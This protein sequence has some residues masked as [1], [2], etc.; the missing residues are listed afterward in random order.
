MSLHSRVIK[1]ALVGERN[2]DTAVEKR[3]IQNAGGSVERRGKPADGTQCQRNRRD[4][5]TIFATKRKCRFLRLPP[6]RL[7]LLARYFPFDLRN[8]PTPS[9][10]E[11][12]FRISLESSCGTIRGGQ[13]VFQ[14]SWGALIIGVEE[15]LRRN[16]KFF[17]FV[18]KRKMSLHVFRFRTRCRFDYLLT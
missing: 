6:D 9:P 7:I 2:S 5:S 14:K 17:S 1:G 3:I 13:N 12:N 4:L 18:G 16:D 11:P 10:N 15:S 8:F